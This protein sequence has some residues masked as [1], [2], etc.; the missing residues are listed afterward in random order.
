MNSFLTAIGQHKAITVVI[1][2]V[3]LAVILPAIV[4]GLLS[5]R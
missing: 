1:A 4:Y 2:L 5:A 3:V